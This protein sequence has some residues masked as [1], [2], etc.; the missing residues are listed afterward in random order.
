MQAVAEK[1]WKKDLNN[2]MTDQVELPV[3]PELP[4]TAE[5]SNKDDLKSSKRF[6][7]KE[8]Q[9]TTQY[10]SPIFKLNFNNVADMLDILVDSCKEWNSTN[11]RIL[12]VLIYLIVRLCGVKF[13]ETRIILTQLNLLTIQTCHEWV[14]T[15]IEEDDLCC[16][17][18]DDRGKYKRDTFYDIYPE[19]EIDAKAFALHNGCKKECRFVVKDLAYFVDE[20]FYELYGDLFEKKSDDDR[21][22]RSEESCR[23]DL[24]EWGARWDSNKNRP[25]FEGN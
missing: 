23:V 24:I 22:I 10:K 5:I 15:V 13:E 3:V 25:Y 12:S 14:L 11:N 18:K 8:T 21:L 1:R 19:L 20:R 4:V 2:N 16:L 6:A 7:S 9:T 17:L